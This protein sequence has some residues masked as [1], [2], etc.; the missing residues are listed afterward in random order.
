MKVGVYIG[1]FQP[2]HIGHLTVIEHM[3]SHYHHIIVMVG[4][5]N[6][7]A[8]IK[9]PFDFELRK[10][11]IETCYKLMA[12][13]KQLV[14][15]LTILPLND[16][17]Y[18]EQ[19]WENEL[20]KKVQNAITHSDTVTLVGHEKDQSS[21]YLK[22][23]PQWA[24]EGIAQS[25]S[26]S[27]TTIR[28]AWF[29]AHLKNIGTVKKYLPQNVI[30]DLSNSCPAHRNLL[31]DYLYY[32]NE[33]QLVIDCAFSDYLKFLSC[34]IVIVTQGH[35]LLIKRLKTPGKDCWALPGGNV[36]TDQSYME[37]ALVN[38][39]EIQEIIL[40]D[41]LNLKN[42]IKSQQLFDLTSRNIGVNR[43]CM[44]YYCELGNTNDKSLPKLN[45]TSHLKDAI[46]MPIDKIK[47]MQLYNDHAD[48]IDQFVEIF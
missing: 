41:G 32:Q 8:S 2:L 5:V 44:A 24:S 45:K 26:I 39:L 9:N 46:W 34:R 33:Q 7:A 3:M 29:S 6:Q 23:F 21:Y 14:P 38:L 35:I 40:M 17:R 10:S 25:I 30:N 22:S 11:W 1:R 43:A 36:K 47:T 19:K 27:A 13:K 31:D 48:I 15:K 12:A 37:A 4:S 16:Y 18:R 28:N 20:E 42:A